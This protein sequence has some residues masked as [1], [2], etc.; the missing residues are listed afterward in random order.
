MSEKS[1]AGWMTTLT[2]AERV[3]GGPAVGGTEAVNVA[4]V[5]P[6][7][8]AG[9]AANVTSIA[10]PVPGK[11]SAAGVA[12]TFGIV[13]TAKTVGVFQPFSA[14]IVNVSLPVPPGV[15][16]IVGALAVSV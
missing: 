4:G 5:V 8:A 2:V 12:V 11:F 9:D 1:G 7:G 6:F 14:V 10:P 16:V 13:G 3:V 15:S